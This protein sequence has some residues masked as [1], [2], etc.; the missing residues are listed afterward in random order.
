[1]KWLLILVPLGL[2]AQTGT[3]AISN[4]AKAATAYM[5][6]GDF[7]AAE[8]EN[9]II[10]RLQP[11]LAEAHVNLGL[12]CFLQRH[13]LDAAG[14]FETG[15]K[16]NASLDNAKLFLGLSE[17]KLNKVSAAVPP[18]Q[19]Y[20][21][22]QPADFQGQYYLGLSY[23]SLERWSNAR[24]ALAAASRINSRNVDVLYHLAQ[25][26]IEEARKDQSKASELAGRYQNAVDRI[27]EI[28]PNSFRLAQLRAAIYERDGK[29]ASAIAELEKIFENDPNA[30]GL[31]YTL[32]CLYMEQHDYT[33]ALQQFQDEQQL[34]TPYFRTDLQIG[35]TYLALEEPSK[36]LPFLEKALQ[37]EPANDGVIL[38]DFGRAYRL[39]N[40]PAKS[41]AAYER[42]I[43]KGQRTA[44][45][46]YQLAMESKKA[47]NL[48]RSSEAL[49][50]S[51]KLRAGG[52]E[53]QASPTSSSP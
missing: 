18:L 30:R 21:S 38:V 17:F 50:M 33:R 41:V 4:H 42:A 26:Y 39:M 51:Q 15:L 47:G 31:H 53:S 36:A 5:Q 8:R 43:A 14:A 46:Y 28:D 6:A 48:T 23:L 11:G 34:D 13:Y 35:H 40:Q 20:V 29:K 12:S 10:V 24:E 9:R 49:T 52:Q 22:R 32:G 3:N 2:V 27:S 45:V 16:L 37:L 1:M 7:A 44:A 25:T 19:Q